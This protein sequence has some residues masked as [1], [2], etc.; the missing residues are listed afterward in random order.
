MSTCNIYKMWIDDAEFI[1]TAKELAKIS[2][3]NANVIGSIERG[4]Q[5]AR[6]G[7]RIELLGRQEPKRPDWNFIRQFQEEWDN[8]IA[9]FKNVEWVSEWHDGVLKLEVR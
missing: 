2:G 1:G 4:E 6:K 5:Q 3:Y 9:L 7:V 8:A